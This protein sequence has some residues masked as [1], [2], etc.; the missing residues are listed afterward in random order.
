MGRRAPCT[1]R[2]GSRLRGGG[3]SITEN[4]LKTHSFFGGLCDISCSA[5]SRSQRN[6]LMR[7]ALF[8]AVSALTPTFR[9]EH[10]FTRQEEL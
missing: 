2:A 9:G 10:Y 1:P 6:C 8:A 7:A 3:P 4:R 5:Q